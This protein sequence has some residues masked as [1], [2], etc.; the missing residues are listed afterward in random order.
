MVGVLSNHLMRISGVKSSFFI[1]NISS[2]KI[3][4]IDSSVKYLKFS[5]LMSL[6]IFRNIVLNDANSIFLL[7]YLSAYM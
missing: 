2:L 3:F 6:K 5:L 4:I 7:L 1:Y